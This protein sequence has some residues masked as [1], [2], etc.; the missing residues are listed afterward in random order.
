[1][2]L[3]TRH[4]VAST[5]AITGLVLL[6]NVPGFAQ[7][8]ELRAEVP[9]D[10]YIAGKLMPAG[11]YVVKALNGVVVRVWDGKGSSAVVNTNAAFNGDPQTPRLVFHRYGNV[12]FLSELYWEGYSAGRAVQKSARELEASNGRTPN[13]IQLAT[14]TKR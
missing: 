6:L 2:K 10:F 12:S 9:F 5:L 4:A 7:S 1:M 14:S 11:T 8:L 3:R 13:T